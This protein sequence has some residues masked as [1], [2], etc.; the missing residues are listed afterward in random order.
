MKHCIF[1]GIAAVAACAAI[2]AHSEEFIWTGTAGGNWGGHN[3]NDGSLFAVGGDAVFGDAAT[4]RVLVDSDVTA[5]KITA[6]DDTTI[7]SGAIDPDAWKTA[8]R[9]YRFYIDGTRSDDGMMQLSDIML[10]DAGGNEIPSSEFTFTFNPEKYNQDRTYP[11]NENPT[12]AVDGVRSTKWLDY[13]AGNS[14][15]S[16]ERAAVW[17]EFRFSSPRNLSGYRWYTANDATSRDPAAWRLLASHDGETWVTLDKV[18][19]FN[20]TGYRKTLAFQRSFAGFSHYRFKV[21]ETRGG[22]YTMQI[23][24]VALYGLDGKRLLKDADFS[25]SYLST[26]ADGG[27][28]YPGGEN[29]NL[30][31]DVNGSGNAITS[32]KWLDWRLEREATRDEVWI[33]FD[34]NAPVN[35]SAYSWSTAND[36]AG[37]YSRNPKTWRLLASND[38]T[39]WAPVDYV[40]NNTSVTTVN[41]TEAYRKSFVSS[42]MSLNAAELEVETGKTLY[43]PGGINVSNGGGISKT[44]GGTLLMGGEADLTV[45]PFNGFSVCEGALEATDVTFRLGGTRTANHDAPFVV[46]DCGGGEATAVLNGGSV[47]CVSPGS[48]PFNAMQIGANSGDTGRLYATNANVTTRGRLRLATGALSMA[49]VEKV[50]GDWRVEE[51][52]SYGQFRMGEG[53]NSSS[54]FYHRSGTLTVYSYI[55]VGGNDSSTIGRNYFEISGGTVTHGLAGFNYPVL[56]GWQG[57]VGVHNELRVT[58]NGVLNSTSYINVAD[59]A[60]GILTIDG[61]EV[62]VPNGRVMVSWSR[63][64]DEPG[65]VNLN[66][67]VLFTMGVVRDDTRTGAADGFLSFNGGTLKAAAEGTL[68]GG[69]R[70]NVSVGA[71]GGT[72]DTDGNA[73]EIARPLLEDEESLGGGMTFKGGNVVALASGNTYAGT[74]T[75][76]LG[77]TLS[78]A[79]ASDIPAEIAVVLPD[80]GAEDGV[81]TVFTV[82]GGETLDAVE[83]ERLSKPDGCTLRLS[84]DSKSVLSIYGNPPNTWIGAA[85]A[86]LSDPNNWSLHL[87]PQ[88][89][90]GCVITSPTEASFYVGDTFAPSYVTFQ[91]GCAAVTIV[92]A[93]GHGLY[94]VRE[95]V[96]LSSNVQTFDVPVSFLENVELN[97]SDAAVCFAGGVTGRTLVLRGLDGGGWHLKGTYNLSYW[98]DAPYCFI[99]D[100]AVVNATSATRLGDVRIEAGGSLVVGNYTLEASADSKNKWALYYNKGLF[101]VT[102][103][104]TNISSVKASMFSGDSNEEMGAEN[105][106]LADKPKNIIENLVN[107]PAGDVDFLLGKYGEPGTGYS[108]WVRAAYQFGSVTWSLRQSRIVVHRGNSSSFYFAK[109]G[110]V[111]GGWNA[112]R[113]GF[114]EGTTYLMSDIEGNP[115]EVVFDCDISM[116][117]YGTGYYGSFAIAGGG[118]FTLA[119][120]RKI[121]MHTKNVSVFGGTT[122]AVVPDSNGAVSTNVSANALNVDSSSTL[123]VSGAGTV[124]L[125]CNLNLED[126]ATLE[127]DAE[128]W[129]DASYPVL[130]LSGNDMTVTLGS[131]KKIKVKA[132]RDGGGRPK[133]G[134]YVLTRG[135]KFDGVEVELASGQPDWAKVSVERGEIVLEVTAGTSIILR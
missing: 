104:F 134:T 85:D 37:W 21:D 7:L 64:A 41:E 74:T 120:G 92:S 67:G 113:L 130:D 115:S 125:A 111:S 59:T 54:E 47:Y 69:D 78:V 93:E 24:D 46:G 129:S 61:G 81:Y 27:S 3:W 75:V 88:S 22:A 12:N 102:D 10:L 45:K 15:T 79:S 2:D 87:V 42:E 39:T 106:A 83:L 19:G 26:A 114:L 128:R 38:G 94:N 133:A 105:A 34:M 53:L 103:T 1:A 80:G 60:P 62:N 117:P 71:N 91:D 124:A 5:N 17:L 30:A 49:F 14:K 121:D 4:A 43:V 95:I 84:A 6:E 89:G 70:L 57:A 100:G 68:I 109:S 126:W 9:Y 40:T 96:N 35:I 73:V 48:E 8:Y 28:T 135:G 63:K 116:E 90:D 33:Q 11:P 25:L 110:I 20:P 66:G 18:T 108:K 119:A 101:H 127:F 44:G 13:R 65:T 99:D 16:V 51:N 123:A 107:N 97:Y 118:R 122:F 86:S 29:P 32:T 82:T 36:T 52:G 56:V 50:G 132:T 31:V 131:E 23:S 77:T 112:Q 58:G 55:C 72:I 98:N 76:E